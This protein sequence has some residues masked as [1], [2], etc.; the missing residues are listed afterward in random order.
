MFRYAILLAVAAFVSLPATAIAQPLGP[1]SLQVIDAKVEKDKL[2]WTETIA[3]PV[4]KEIAVEVRKNGM[5]FIEKRT[6][7]VLEFQQ[8]TR[9]ME[10]KTLKATDAAGKAIGADKLAEML[11][12]S[13]PVVVAHAAIPEKHRKLFKETT[14]FVELPKPE[15]PKVPVPAQPIVVP[16][17]GGAPPIVLP[18]GEKKG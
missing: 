11:K 3:V 18:P 16:A 7:T 12:E 14:V 9:T 10:L 1:G 6:V 8:I 4:T 13:T 17:P 5:A 15:V 2:T